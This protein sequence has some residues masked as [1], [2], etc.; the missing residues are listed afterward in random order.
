MSLSTTSSM[1][2]RLINHTLCHVVFP[3]LVHISP[4]IRNQIYN[5]EFE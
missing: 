3:S 1:H 4:A 5:L 2:G